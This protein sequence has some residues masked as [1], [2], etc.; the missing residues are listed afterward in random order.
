[1]AKPIRTCST[2]AGRQPPSSTQRLLPMGVFALVVVCLMLLVACDPESAAPTATT[3]AA[4]AVV[5]STPSSLNTATFAPEA[6]TATAVV[7]P[8]PIPPVT[9][10]AGA[11]NTA[12][13]TRVPPATATSPVLASAI[14]TSKPAQAATAASSP[15][16]LATV[17]VLARPPATQTSDSG[18]NLRYVFPVRPAS[19]TTY[20]QY[21]HDYPATDIFCPIGS[22]FVAPTD[23]VVDFVSIKDSWDPSVDDPATRGGLSVAI[24]GADGVRYYGS[25]LSALE[26]GIM[27]GVH[28]AAGQVLGKTGKSGD[29]RFTDS[30][31]HFGISPPTTPADWET[32]RGII[33]PYKYLRAWEAGTQLQPVLP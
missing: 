12:T 28:V 17:P 4:S 1:M 13:P 23:G 10:T 5:T 25:H 27:P 2:L 30:H 32:R 24:I 3:T 15:T 20:G 14:A 22:L 16:P 31:L 21:H 11:T 9:F 19:A 18:A 33:S 29:A 26:P 7:S 8:T 6:A